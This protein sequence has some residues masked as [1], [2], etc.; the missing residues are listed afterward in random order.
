MSDYN[1]QHCATIHLVLR[2]RGGGDDTLPAKDESSENH[3]MGIAA[4]GRIDQVIEADPKIHQ[5]DSSQTKWF[6]VQILN[7]SKFKEVTGLS[8]PKTPADAQMYADHGYPFYELW[9]EEDKKAVAGDF[10]GV[11][12]I[13]QIDGKVEAPLKLRD[14]IKIGRK[15]PDSKASTPGSE[16]KGGL[17]GFFT[18]R[19]RS[20]SESPALS[21]SSPPVVTPETSFTSN[22]EVSF[23]QDSKG[24][25]EF[26]GLAEFERYLA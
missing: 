14:I 9:G 6:N 24:L 26:K 18:R 10:D 7:S 1:I 15:K 19:S 5:W 4:G 16:R 23:F 13:G 17:R 25:P 11:Q 2:L 8:A 20:T 21:S 22:I 3:E 12:S